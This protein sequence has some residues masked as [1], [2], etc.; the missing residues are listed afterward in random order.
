[1][2][3]GTLRGCFSLLGKVMG[4]TTKMSNSFFL[5]LNFLQGFGKWVTLLDENYLTTVFLVIYFTMSNV[6]IH[7]RRVFWVR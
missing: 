1:M 5:P 3:H 2:R 6:R 4:G 7:K